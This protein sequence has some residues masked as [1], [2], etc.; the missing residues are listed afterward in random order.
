[1]DDPDVVLGIHTDADRPTHDPMVRQRFWPHW[2]HFKHGR[3]DSGCL[4]RRPLLKQQRADSENGNER[5]NQT[6]PSG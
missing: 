2:I 4:N 3:L 6:N 5:D 1:M